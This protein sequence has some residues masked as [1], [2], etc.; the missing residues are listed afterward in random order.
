MTDAK[1]RRMTLDDLGFCV[2][3]FSHVGWGNTVDDVRRMLF[4][5][6]DGCFIASL[7][8]VDVG[9]V[10]STGYGEVGW[11][12]NLIVLPEHRGR[13]IG[14]ALME[15][16]IGHLQDAGARSVRLD[17]V[18]RAVPLYRRLGFREEYPSLRFRGQGRRLPSNGVERMSQADLAG[19]VELDKRFFG[20][21]RER[22]LK[23]VLQDFPGLC[24]VARVDGRVTG[25]VMAKVGEGVYR[26]GPW[27]CEPEK[28]EAAEGLLR[29]LMSEAAGQ[30]LWAGVPGFNEASVEMLRE[31]GF[32]VMP[33]SLRMCYGECKPM[34]DP[35]GVFGIGA[36]DKG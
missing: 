4:Y 15:A 14:A 5:E 21:P 25:Y 31:S 20:A 35:V 24:F 36:P 26:I 28:P 22:M 13:G 6:P 7:G 9:M 32:E 19:V 29:R 8:G 11:V 12:G 33:P 16:A 23:R 27:I 34:G 17:S 18:P 30:R 3:L 10:A 2:G 1:I